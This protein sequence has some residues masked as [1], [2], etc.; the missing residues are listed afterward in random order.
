MIGKNDNYLS[1]KKRTNRANK[2]EKYQR[3]SVG[4]GTM[5]KE[6]GRGKNVKKVKNVPVTKRKRCRRPSSETADR[7]LSKKFK[8]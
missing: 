3:D 4:K 7:V 5:K 1:F 8:V 6:E 2:L